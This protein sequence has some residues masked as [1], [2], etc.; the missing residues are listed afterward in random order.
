VFAPIRA[1]PGC[2]G[3]P[4]SAPKA[5]FVSTSLRVEGYVLDGDSTPNGV[6]K[7]VQI[8]F[9]FNGA[10]VGRG[11]G[12]VAGFETSVLLI[13]RDIG[14]SFDAALETGGAAVAGDTVTVPHAHAETGRSRYGRRMSMA[15]VVYWT[16]RARLSNGQPRKP[17][18]LFVN[19]PEPSGCD[20]PND[21]V[22]I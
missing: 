8:Q 7:P 11:Q 2:P 22:V 3:A 15:H 17:A 16:D 9:D 10:N 4:A 5:T 18:T 21:Q 13:R 19:V 20:R 6:I 14:I 12:Q 1:R